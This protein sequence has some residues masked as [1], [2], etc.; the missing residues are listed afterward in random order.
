MK[1]LQG[2]RPASLSKRQW[3]NKTYSDS[4]KNKNKKYGTVQMRT[5]I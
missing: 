3:V 1:N 5:V 2:I 4:V